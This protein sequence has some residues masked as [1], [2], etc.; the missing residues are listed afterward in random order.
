MFVAFGIGLVLMFRPP[1]E[2]EHGPEVKERE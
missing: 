1:K 2:R